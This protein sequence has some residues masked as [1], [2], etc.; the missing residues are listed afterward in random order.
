M[1]LCIP[2]QEDK[3]LQSGINPHFG[4]AAYFLVVDT[5][6]GGCRSISNRVHD[7]GQ[8]RPAES[9]SE[10]T[11]DGVVVGGIGRGALLNLQSAGIRVYL[12]NDGTAGEAVEKFK[13]NELPAATSGECCGGHGEHEGG[14][15]HG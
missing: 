5:E 11:I 1:K 12:S 13:S 9:L 10:E 4:S 2:V 14:C 15:S 3:G 7:Q 6:T 8:C